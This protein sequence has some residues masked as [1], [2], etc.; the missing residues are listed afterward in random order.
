MAAAPAHA[1]PGFARGGCGR[2]AVLLLAALMLAGCASDE[3]A[4]Y[5]RLQDDLRRSGFM[6]TERV[7]A[8]APFS[9]AD[10]IRDF[11]L[12]ALYSE[13]GRRNDRFVRQTSPSVLAKWT[14]PIRIRLIFGR[15]V[16]SDQR[17]SDRRDV[18]DFTA[19]LARLS[20]LEIGLADEDAPANFII[21]YADARERGEIAEQIARTNPQ[22]DP[23]FIDSLRSSP[24]AEVCYVNTFWSDEQPGRIVFAVTVIKAE[25]RG[26]MRLSC[27]HEELTQALGLAN[28]DPRVRP[29]IF[30][31]D[32]EFAL[33]T[34]HDE[35]LLRMLYHPR[36]KPGMRA[37][38][39]RPLLP[40]ILAQVKR[41]LR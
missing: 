12:V 18:E 21:I 23:A 11:E 10:L 34:L 5:A 37:D 6:R 15:S 7:P 25:A 19:R 3:A 33:L 2:L 30:N 9:D 28:D 39:V 22:A 31:D 14:D 20:G 29:S 4:L 1:S 24:P 36:L 41:E 13:F 8:D 32:E 27:V 35:I 26:L 17:R 40:G 38:E 16:G